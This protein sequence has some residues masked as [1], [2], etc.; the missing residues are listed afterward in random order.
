MFYNVS[1][2]WIEK[3]F[4]KFFIDITVFVIFNTTTTPILFLVVLSL[5]IQFVVIEWFTKELRNLMA[6]T[7]Y[8]NHVKWNTHLEDS[9]SVDKKVQYNWLCWKIV[10]KILKILEKNVSCVGRKVIFRTLFIVM[11]LG[12][13]LD[14]NI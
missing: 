10:K 9:S 6:K 2:Y 11:K 8:Q 12:M 1:T 7:F 4:S 5:N 14:V 13:L 3:H